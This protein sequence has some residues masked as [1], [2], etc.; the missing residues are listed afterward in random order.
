M[1]RLLIE[2]SIITAIF[3]S[4]L[5]I[6][7]VAQEL[8]DW[9]D[10]IHRCWSTGELSVS[11][12]K[13]AS[14][15][16]N[17]IVSHLTDEQILALDPKTGKTLWDRDLAGR[18]ASPIIISG[19][20]LYFAVDLRQPQGLSEKPS[21][22][23]KSSLEIAAVDLNSGLNNGSPTTVPDS[24]SDN[25]YSIIITNELLYI[26]SI[27][28]NIYA[29]RK[30]DRTLVWR[31]ELNTSLSADPLILRDHIYVGTGNKTAIKISAQSGEIVD[32]IPL[33]FV[34]TSLAAT[35]SRLFAGDKEGKISSI[36]FSNEQ[37]SWRSSTGGEIVEINPIGEDI[38]VSSNDNFVYRF[39]GDRGRKIWKRKLSGRI[40][41][42]VILRD[43]IG[44]FLSVGSNEVLLVDLENGKLVNRISIRGSGYFVSA[45]IYTD[46]KIILPTDQGLEAYSPVCGPE[47]KS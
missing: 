8:R 2:W 39:S 18:L 32:Q 22:I 10:P 44:A 47:P 11:S 16:D 4:S 3:V 5:P 42:N 43:K 28:G 36:E 21:E 7:V 37:F 1:Y 15:N 29:L 30:N 9:T 25:E 35:D 14:D 38:L 12:R 34:P 46:N 31:A 41:G 27:S 24:A 33:G 6:G 26:A 13:H 19:Q 45:P 17:T 23:S 40:L 20:T